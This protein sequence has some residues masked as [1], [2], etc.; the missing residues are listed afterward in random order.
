MCSMGNKVR[1]RRNR[2]YWLVQ[3]QGSPLR[4]ESSSERA[5]PLVI[6]GSP[7]S[8]HQQLAMPLRGQMTTERVA[9]RVKHVNLRREGH[10]S[11][12]WKLIRG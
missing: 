2:F 8:F 6:W 1:Q 3:N 9:S 12:L 11:C 10:P 5:L 4:D 7:G